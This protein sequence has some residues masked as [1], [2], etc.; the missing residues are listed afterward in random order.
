MESFQLIEHPETIRLL[1]YP[2]LIKPNVKI[3]DIRKV[4]KDKI[5]IK[6]E[7]QRFELVGRDRYYFEFK[8]ITIF[9]KILN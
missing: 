1:D 8:G 7:N 6:E 9:G 2:E 3:D 5:G 4:I